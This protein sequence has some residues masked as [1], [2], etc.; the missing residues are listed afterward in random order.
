MVPPVPNRFS[1]TLA[2]GPRDSVITV[3][4]E[5]DLET[6]PEL[7]QVLDRALEHDGTITVD[8]IPCSFIDSTGL[9]QLLRA[10][11]AAAR[12]G[13]RFLIVAEPDSPADRLVELVAPGLFEIVRSA[14]I[15][16]RVRHAPAQSLLEEN[17]FDT[18]AV[19]AVAPP[20]R[21]RFLLQRLVAPHGRRLPGPP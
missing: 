6:A 11:E 13:R 2:A 16:A 12:S 8:L 18:P 19:R 17:R 7:T 15:T 9:Q 21:V 20:A 10:R 3:T 14:G 4:G 1:A 5:V